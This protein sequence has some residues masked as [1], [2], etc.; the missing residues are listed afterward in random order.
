MPMGL[1][2]GLL[3]ASIYT[4]TNRCVLNEIYTHRKLRPRSLHRNRRSLAYLACLAASAAPGRCSDA[5]GWKRSPFF[6]KGSGATLAD[7]ITAWF[8]QS[9]VGSLALVTRV[10]IEILV[11]CQHHVV[12]VPLAACLRMLLVR[13]ESA[14]I[15]TAQHVGHL[16]LSPLGPLEL[17]LSSLAPKRRKRPDPLVV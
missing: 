9:I 15:E 8:H 3:V 14:A 2:R 5:C 16:L 12:L 7:K 13:L 1:I 6:A 10:G 11:A 17:L 4:Y